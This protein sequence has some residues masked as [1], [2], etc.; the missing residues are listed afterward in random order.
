MKTLKVRI[1]IFRVHLTAK[2]KNNPFFMKTLKIHEN[3][4]NNNYIMRCFTPFIS[5]R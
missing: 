1:T 5:K 3:L 4:E 2:L